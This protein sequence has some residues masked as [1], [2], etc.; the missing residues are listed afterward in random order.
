MNSIYWR[1]TSVNCSVVIYEL[2]EKNK[3]RILVIMFR[4][5]FRVNGSLSCPTVRHI[6]LKKGA[7]RFLESNIPA[8][9]LEIFA[10][11]SGIFLDVGLKNMLVFRR[12]EILQDFYNFRIFFQIFFRFKLICTGFGIFYYFLRRFLE[13]YA[14]RVWQWS[15]NRIKYHHSCV[16]VFKSSWVQNDIIIRSM[17]YIFLYFFRW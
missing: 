4:L 11:F 9:L 8:I 10:T 17:Y 12:I 3:I 5:Y 16:V 15:W 13:F 2:F 6:A 14:P 7:R 1:L